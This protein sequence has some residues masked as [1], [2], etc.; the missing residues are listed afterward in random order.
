MAITCKEIPQQRTFQL[1]EKNTRTYTRTWEVI[2]DDPNIGQLEVATQPGLDIGDTYS[3]STESDPLAKVTTIGSDCISAD[4]RTWK[5]VVTYSSL[6]Q[7]DTNPLNQPAE[8]SW[9]CQQF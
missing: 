6:A 3:T 1:D 8:I 5:V 4:G 2:T 7:S 9:S